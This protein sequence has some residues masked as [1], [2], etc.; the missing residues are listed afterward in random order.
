MSDPRPDF[1]LIEEKWLREGPSAALEALSRTFER[2]RRLP[3]LFEALLMK[4]R[5]ALGLPL[6]PLGPAADLP[7]EVLRPHEEAI[8]AACR[9]VGRLF[10][11]DGDLVAAWPYFRA[12]GEP[13]A[14]AEAIGRIEPGLQRKDLDG[15]ID[16]AFYQGVHPRRGLEV[17][18]GQSGICSAITAMERSLPATRLRQEECAKVLVRAL[19]RELYH[20]IAQDIARRTPA[21]AAQGA[22]Q[23]E[24][25]PQGRLRDLIAGRPWLF[26]HGAYHVDPSHLSA[27]VRLSGF[28]AVGS[29]LELALEMAEYGQRLD[30][31]YQTRC[32]PPFESL[33]ADHALFLR[34]RIS[35]RGEEGARAAVHFAQKARDALA[36]R[37][38]H[39]PLGAV[40]EILVKL[41]RPGEAV[42]LAQEL[43]PE[44]RSVPI[45]TIGELCQGAGEFRMLADVARKRGDLLYFAA[46]L[47][48]SGSG[49]IGPP[50][51]G[52]G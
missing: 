8:A 24:T 26:E 19:H 14:V 35:P 1:A 38:E 20:S 25:P 48:Q 12:L 45:S 37:V 5:L 33:Y 42:A 21:D 40:V 3:Q 23:R 49:P 13:E 28:M 15:I 7:E 46:A 43:D 30:A 18:I 31:M 17:I 27:V 36:Q 32:D 4:S 2:E 9:K 16:I 41:A 39:Y 44:G 51:G 34:G 11:E 50:A 6:V 47:V 29:E 52:G 10:L 22:R